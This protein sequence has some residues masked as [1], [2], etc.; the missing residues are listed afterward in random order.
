MWFSIKSKI[1]TKKLIKDFNKLG[2]IK[3][4]KFLLVL[5]NYLVNLILFFDKKLL[6]TSKGVGLILLCKKD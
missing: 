3:K 2:N 5:I 1:P 4:N 6:N